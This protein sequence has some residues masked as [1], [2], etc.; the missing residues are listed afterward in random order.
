MNTNTNTNMDS[1]RAAT[2]ND[3][4][5]LGFSSIVIPSTSEKKTMSKVNGA[6]SLLKAPQDNFLGTIVGGMA[7]TVL[8]STAIKP[9]CLSYIQRKAVL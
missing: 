3:Q 8:T 5:Q 7:T 1:L 4:R 2:N 6:E 9:N